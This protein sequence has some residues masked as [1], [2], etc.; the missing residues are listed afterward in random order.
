MRDQ[1]AVMRFGT[2][3]STQFRLTQAIGRALS[4]LTPI[5][6][7][8]VV[9]E[10]GDTALERGDVD[11]CFLKSVVN[12][13]RYMGKGYYA[14]S[15]P[16]TWLRTIAWLP[17]E[18]RF[19]FAVAPWTGITSFEDIAAQKPALQI[20]GR[21]GAPLLEAYGF[22]FED[23]ERW[24]GSVGSVAHTARAVKERYDEGKLDAL[25][26][27]GSAYDGTCWP[28]IAERG[29]RF[30]DIREDVMQRLEEQGLRRNI[31]V[32]GTFRGIT[33]S[34]LALDDSHIVATCHERLDDHVAYCLA[35]AI[36]EQKRQIEC[37]SIQVSY[38]ESS[39]LPLTQTT[40]WSSLTSQIE[41]QWD[42]KVLGAPLHPGA[43]RY[44]KER[45]LL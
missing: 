21:V 1:P 26:G 27:D 31:T 5:K 2:S 10:R 24:S 16:S 37:E 22:S 43:A 42:P 38:G 32:A 3:W 36:D 29:Y 40:Y 35:R 7:T 25:F 12:E 20:A 8:V 44:Y 33:Q 23:I 15:E 28:W 11:F 17:Q 18:D 30:L 19:F 9:G 4:E 45:G 14:G 39:A 41:R 34:L 6:A 13:H